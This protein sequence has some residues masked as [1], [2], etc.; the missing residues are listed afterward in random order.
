MSDP[1]KCIISN[2]VRN[3]ISVST[4]SSPAFKVLGV[5][6][7]VGNANNIV[8]YIE[9]GLIPL[10]WLKTIYDKPMTLDELKIIGGIWK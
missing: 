10:G 1:R 3:Q 4:L 8:E 9:R 2:N 6:F 5:M 7:N